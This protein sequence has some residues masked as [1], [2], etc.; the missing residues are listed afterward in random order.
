MQFHPSKQNVSPTSK[1]FS[2]LKSLRKR[3]LCTCFLAA[4]QRKGF[5]NM[6]KSLGLHGGR[7]Y[8][9]LVSVALLDTFHGLTIS[10]LI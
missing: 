2:L 4:W 5:P 9:G 1:K 10:Q 6:V 8:G 7:V 3:L